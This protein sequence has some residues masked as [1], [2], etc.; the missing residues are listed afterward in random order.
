MRV[1]RGE[2]PV[3]EGVIESL[4]A[5]KS[6]VKEAAAGTECGMSFKGKIKV[7]IGDRFEAYTEESKTRKI[8]ITR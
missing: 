1:W 7:L 4:Q 6:P 2:E 3:G 5:G 8:E